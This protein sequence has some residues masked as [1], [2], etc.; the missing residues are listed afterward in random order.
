MARG[1]N[2]AIIVGSL[3]KEPETRYTQSGSAV[4]SFSVATSESWKD[5]QSGEKVEHTEW[6]QVTAFG[7]LAEICGEYLRK[8]SQVYIEG[9]IKTESYDKDG[10]TRYST[11]IIANEMQMLGGKDNSNNKPAQKQGSQPAYQQQSQQPQQGSS[12]GDDFSDDIPFTPVSSMY[13]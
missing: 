8:G 9:K 2:K 10:I 1:I 4:T 3:G 13:G 5:K 7:K 11:K 6:H 12:A